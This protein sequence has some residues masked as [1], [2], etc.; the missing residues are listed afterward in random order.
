MRNGNLAVKARLQHDLKE[1]KL[2][3]EST[4]ELSSLNLICIEHPQIIWKMV[5]LLL[6]NELTHKL[7]VSSYYRI[8]VET[9]GWS[10]YVLARPRV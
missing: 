2:L 10:W 3:Q 8:I 4:G 9:A 7:I 5:R 6:L 1:I